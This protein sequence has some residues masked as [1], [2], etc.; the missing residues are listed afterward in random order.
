MIL[1]ILNYSNGNANTHKTA[2]FRVKQTKPTGVKQ[3]GRAGRCGGSRGAVPG[4]L[5]SPLRGSGR[6]TCPEEQGQWGQRGAGPF[7]ALQGR[8]P[9]SGSGSGSLQRCPCDTL[10]AGTAHGAG[11][12]GGLVT[13]G[14]CSRYI[15]GPHPALG[16]PAEPESVCCTLV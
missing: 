16:A 6:V 15:L 10:A 2:E 7:P 14:P 13:S 11:A 3:G 8:P 4:R 12:V 9:G 5:W 1:Q